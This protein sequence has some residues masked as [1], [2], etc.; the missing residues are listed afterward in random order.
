MF[1]GN[2]CSIP[3]SAKPTAN[4]QSLPEFKVFDSIILDFME[5]QGI[6]GASVV[7]SK[8]DIVLYTQSKILHV[9]KV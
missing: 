6:P 1:V 9:Y 4:L 7:V 8:G 3:L 5:E 2:I